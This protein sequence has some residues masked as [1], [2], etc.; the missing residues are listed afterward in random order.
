MAEHAAAL[1]EKIAKSE[2]KVMHLEENKPSD[3]DGL[4]VWCI[5]FAA[6]TKNLEQQNQLLILHMESK[7]KGK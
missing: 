3:K 5:E 1:I 4:K 6:A 7:Q 2:V